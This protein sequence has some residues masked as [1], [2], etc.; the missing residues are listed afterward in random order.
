M[1]PRK[2]Q[3]FVMH[4]VGEIL[5]DSDVSQWRWIPTKLNVADAATKVSSTIKMENWL[6]G[7]DFLQLPDAEWTNFECDSQDMDTSE[8]R[9]HVFATRKVPSI[10]INADYFSEWRRLYRAVATFLLYLERLKAI[11]NCKIKPKMV[12][13]EMVRRAKSILYQQAQASVYSFEIQSLAAG[14][15]LSKQSRLFGLNVYIDVNGILRTHGRL[16]T[17]NSMEDAVVL[18][19][20]NHTTFLLVKSH[21][22]KQHHLNHETAINNIK[23]VYHIPR[24]RILFRSV[25]QACQKC[26]VMHAVPDPPQMAPIPA[27][28]LASYSKPFTYTGL[29]YFG[30]ILVNVGRHKE[31]RWGVLFTCLTL[32][33]VHIEIAY[34]LDTSSCIMCI[35][36]FMARRGMPAEFYSDN[37][38]NFRASEKA[39]REELVK[40]DY[41]EI[42]VKYDSIKWHFNPPGAPH[43]GGAWERLVR[44]T[45]TVL[46]SI[47]P[48]YSFNDESLR[49]ALME[50]EY[51]INS[52][53]LTF[54]SL[55]SADDIALTPNHLL[56]GSADGYKPVATNIWISGS[57]GIKLNF[58]QIGF[59]NVG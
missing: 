13:P 3:Q 1:D 4:R 23:S 43:M 17:I 44:S 5:E 46:K 54:V 19:R 32:R 2:F 9:K 8:M 20:E 50:A 59:G 52:R 41:D 48:T 34:S 56:L 38:T 14:N 31:K 22:E 25:R 10:H 27:V 57:D 26:K 39:V 33:A 40:L 35:R 21:H 55:E 29:D 15:A 6:H 12:T 37:G 28:R 36:N 16:N 49:S 53:P 30:P 47:C 18:P 58:S 45:K 51:I 24:L 42:M 7:P 11:I